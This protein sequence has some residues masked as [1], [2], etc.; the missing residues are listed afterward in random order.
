MSEIERE[1][2]EVDVLFV[3]AGPA[4][5][6]SA[7]H[8]MKQVEA[9]NESAESEG[10][11]PIEPPTVLVI[12]KAAGVGDHQLSGAVINPRA[13]QEL[14]PDFLEQGFPTEYVC[15]DSQ[16][17]AFTRS[18]TFKSPIVPPMFQKNGYHVASLSN[19]VKWLAEK[20]EAL[21]VEIYPGFAGAKVL[22]EGDRVLGV[23]IGDMGVDK[24]GNPK[25]NFEPGMDILAKVTVLGEGV[26]GSLA[27]QL[28]DDFDLH[29]EN[30]QTYETGI[31]EIWRVKPEKHK[32]GRVIHGS[33][34]PE[35]FSKLNG[36]WLYDMKDNLVS[37]GYVTPLDTENPNNDPHRN[38]QVFKTVPFMRDLLDGAE[39]VRYGA[40]CIPTGGLYAQ[41]KLYCNGAMLLG[42]SASMLNIMKLAGVHMAM[43]SGMLAAETIVDAMRADDYSSATLGGYAE[44]FRESWAY[45]EHLE[46]RNFTGSAE[47]GHQFFLMNAPLL[48]P[49]KGRGLLDNLKTHPS[50]QA[51]KKLWELPEEE[52]VPEPFEFDGKLTFSKEHLVGFSGTQ[53]EVD[54][55]CHLK[56]A[57]REVC[58]NQCAVEYGNPCEKFCPAAVYEM[59]PDPDKPGKK[60]MFVHH[61][62]CVHCKTCD[63]ADPYQIITWTPP[64]GG[65]GPNYEQM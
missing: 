24:D 52:R 59:V 4:T 10:R 48:I 37:F 50:H 12:E 2:M 44:R 23:R 60:K 33:L 5:L 1:S 36:M 34:F 3:G 56:I 16:F 35:F 63:I 21:G 19:V 53:H 8:L 39:L 32:P 7:Y 42:D 13:I 47:L 27:K 26:R 41:P 30:P 62:N 20:C 28:I 55:P 61:E 65:E 9:A 11:E 6:A 31:K 38:A 15:D 57:D 46:A 29:G 14:M 54:Q 64:Q 40:K 25:S 18:F 43:K 49:T 58:A 45:Q 22:T 17:M 51:M